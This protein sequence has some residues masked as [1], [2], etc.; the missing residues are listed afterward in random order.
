MLLGF[1]TEYYFEAC[2][3]ATSIYFIFFALD[4]SVETLLH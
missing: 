1:G 4:F 3:L 2:F